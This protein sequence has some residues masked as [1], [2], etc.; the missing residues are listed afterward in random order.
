M[1]IIHVPGLEP[2]RIAARVS[3]LDVFPTIASLMGAPIPPAVRGRDLV[4]L[5]SGAQKD[6]PG[7][8]APAF[9]QLLPYPAFKHRM[10]AIVDGRLKLIHRV[11]ENVFELYDLESD[12]GEK[13]NLIADRPEDAEAMKRKLSEWRS[14]LDG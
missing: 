4:P 7:A 10:E 6:G 8:S 14:T 5:I 2:K 13:H 1:L 9:A 3:L 11:S 12:P